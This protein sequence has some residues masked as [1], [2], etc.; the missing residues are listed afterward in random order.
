MLDALMDKTIAVYQL[1]RTEERGEKVYE[2]AQDEEGFEIRVECHLEEKKGR[3]F[4]DRGV[5]V[6]GDAQMLWQARADG[7]PR[8]DDLVVVIPGATAYQVASKETQAQIGS[9]V[10]YSRAT[11]VFYKTK[12]TA[13]KV[14]GDD[15]GE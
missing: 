9:G 10:S 1:D 5:R 12:L 3:T 15:D 13:P 6:T 8:E 4:D 14:L 11:L 2:E 7:L